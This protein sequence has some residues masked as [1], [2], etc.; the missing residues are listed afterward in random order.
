MWDISNN[1]GS[2]RGLQFEAYVLH[3]FRKGDCSFTI[4]HLKGRGKARRRKKQEEFT[5]SKEPKV[6]HIRVPENISTCANNNIL[7]IPNKP[8]FGAADFI[9]TPANIFQATVAKNHPI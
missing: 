2:I 6:E 9:M 8:N 5:I 4:R 7:I 3:L 1:S